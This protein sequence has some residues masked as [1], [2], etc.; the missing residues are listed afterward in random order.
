SVGKAHALSHSR[1]SARPTGVDQPAR[2]FVPF[3]LVAQHLGI[4]PG[5]AGKE[6]SSEACAEC[7]LGL[8]PE[9]TLRT[10]YLGRVAGQEMIHCLLRSQLRNRRQDAKRI[11]CQE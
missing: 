9:A 2:Y 5:M 6:R 3:Q 4:N 7:G 10:C 1:T 8:F 11:G